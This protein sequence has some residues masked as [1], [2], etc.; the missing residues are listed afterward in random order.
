M[1][2]FTKYG[3]FEKHGENLFDEFSNKFELVLGFYEN[4]FSNNIKIELVHES[5]NLKMT[6]G[7]INY[8]V[9]TKKW[10][11]F[12]NNKLVGD[13]CSIFD[14]FGDYYQIDYNYNS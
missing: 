5:L 7:N 11:V 1:T 13:V 3:G 6:Y 12:Y 10:F 8:S 9:N 4:L 2:D 14:K